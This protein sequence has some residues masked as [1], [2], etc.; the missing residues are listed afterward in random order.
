VNLSGKVKTDLPVKKMT[1][2]NE[3]PEELLPWYENGTLSKEESTLV[4]KHLSECTHCQQELSFLHALHKQVKSEQLDLTP[5]EFGLKRLLRDIKQ[6]DKPAKQTYPWW[7]KAFATAA[8]IVIVVQSALLINFST[9]QTDAIVPLGV[10]LTEKTLQIRFA[11]TANE[12]QI[13][14]ILQSVN[15]TLVDGPGAL[16]IYQIRLNE[17]DDQEAAIDR[18]ISRLKSQPEIITFVEKSYPL[19]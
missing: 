10:K 12:Q 2:V 17:G 16:G 19:R 11:P 14:D 7:P 18:V 6:A 9:T 15:A 4:E 5:G 3:H 1:R 8:A 13:R